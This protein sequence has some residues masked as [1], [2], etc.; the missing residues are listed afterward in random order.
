[1]NAAARFAARPVGCDSRTCVARLHRE[2]VMNKDNIKGK[3]KENKGKVKEVVGRA[4]GDKTMEQDGK[5]D[6]VSG[7]VQ[8]AVGDLKEALTPKQ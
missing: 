8:S 2:I 6:Q 5:I 1:M 4:I 3:I 7:K